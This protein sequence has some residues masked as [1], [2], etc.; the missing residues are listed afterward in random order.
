MFEV[1]EQVVWQGLLVSELPSDEWNCG[2]VRVFADAWKMSTD[3]LLSSGSVLIDPNDL[4]GESGMSGMTL[5][6]RLSASS[7]GSNSVG[8]TTLS[9]KGIPNR[10]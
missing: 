2:R 9:A 8:A 5:S 7:G 1:H 10:G 4:N 3:L 6:K